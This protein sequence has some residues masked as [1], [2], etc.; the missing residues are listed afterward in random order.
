MVT[1][2]RYISQETPNVVAGP[3]LR[4]QASPEAFGGG[5]ADGLQ[6]IAGAG[7]E[8]AEMFQQHAELMQAQ[9]NAAE[10]DRLSTEYMQAV[11]ELNYGDNGY[12]TQEGE[13]AVKGFAPAKEA[14][15]KLREDINKKASNPAVA[16]AYDSATRG[17]MIFNLGNMSGHYAS[18]RKKYNESTFKGWEA[19]AADTLALNYNDVAM[20]DAGF[21]QAREKFVA[22]GQEHGLPF[23]A[24]WARYQDFTQKV[25]GKGILMKSLHDVRGAQDEADRYAEMLG[26]DQYLNISSQLL[27]KLKAEDAREMV[28]GIVGGLEPEAAGEIILPFANVADAASQIVKAIPG[29]IITSTDNVPDKAAQKA[30]TPNNKHKVG[31]ALDM[32]IPGKTPEQMASAVRAVWGGIP[33]VKIIAEHKGD[34]HSTGD[35]VHVEWEDATRKHPVEAVAGAKSVDFRADGSK[36]VASARAAALAKRP[37]DL[38]YADM[39]EGLMRTEINQVVAEQT[40]KEKAGADYLISAMVNNQQEGKSPT[41]ETYLRDPQWAAAYNA[42]PA[43]TQRALN[44]QI[45]SA[46]KV[47]EKTWTPEKEA[48]WHELEGMA[49]NDPARFLKVNMLAEDIPLAQRHSL[50]NKQ[51]RISAKQPQEVK[52]NLNVALADPLVKQGLGVAKVEGK[53]YDEYVGRLNTE[54]DAWI[55][56]HGKKPNQKELRS[57]ATNILGAQDTTEF[58]G[59]TFKGKPRYMD[60]D[61]AGI[62]K[63]VPDTEVAL[64][65]EALRAR[66]ITPTPQLIQQLYQAKAAN[67]R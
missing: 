25:Y 9:D 46:A 5:I 23:E 27:P 66:G 61:L 2:P 51:L 17:Q 26:P 15:V 33:G 4:A 42:Q 43:Q 18:E 53:K 39:V 59:M 32:V 20:R 10:A 57:M 47:A 19:T 30:R 35:H 14:L 52:N 16:K 8:A 38:V 56:L 11:N 29:A 54:I 13:N 49:V 31:R 64:A 21:D 41:I 60:D 3:G 40:Y 37:G 63:G 58:L 28:A 62:V 7:R 48:R 67:G 65:A 1:V 6:A 44:N 34:K 55:A 24:V 45:A 12:Y 36:L 22:Y 50:A